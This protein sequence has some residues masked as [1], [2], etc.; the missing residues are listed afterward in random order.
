MKGKYM[1]YQAAYHRLISKALTQPHE[2]YTETHHIIPRC[3]GGDDSKSNLVRL[4]AKQHF[5]AHHLLFKIYGGLKLAHAWYS[6]C[7]VGKGQEA[8]MVNARLFGRARETR[9][10]LLSESS[11]GRMNHFYGKTHNEESRQKMSKAQKDLKLWEK[12]SDAHRHA[13]LASQKKPK[14]DD[15]KSKIGRKGMIMLQHTETGEIVRV[16]K[17][18]ARAASE[19]W[20]NPRK[21]SPETRY[22]CL[23][24]GILTTPANLKRWHNDKCKQKET[25]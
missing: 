10:K 20:V 15:H 21:L 19:D 17:K 22:L 18:D 9:S 24:C 23:H 14:T 11:M 1:D 7:R 25:L 8:R 12:R 2:G 16:D 3:V 5:V 13:L 4:S 6:M